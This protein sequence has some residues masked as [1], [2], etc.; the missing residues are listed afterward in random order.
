VLSFTGKDFGPDEQVTV[1]LNT[2]DGQPLEIIQ[3]SPEGSFE[4]AGGFLVPFGLH[5]KQTLIFIGQQSKA[6]TTASFDTLQ[7]TP[8]AQPSTY[9]GRP[10]TTLTFYAVGF[11]R[12]EIV[13]AVIDRT[14][15]SAGRE[16]SCFR[17]DPQGNAASA[18]SYV[19]PGDALPG[20]LIF[21]LLG[22]KS[23]AAATAALEVIASEVPVQVP[24]AADFQCELDDVPLGAPMVGATPVPV[25]ALPAAPEPVLGPAP[26][27]PLPA[28]AEAS[29]AQP[30]VLPQPQPTEAPKPTVQAAPSPST[31]AAAT[32]KPS[33]TTRPGAGATPKTGATA[34]PPKATPA[35]TPAAPAAAP[36]AAPPAATSYTIAAGDT[37]PSIAQ[38]VYGDANL[39]RR[40]Y[41]A[42]KES[43]GNNPNLIKPG[44]QLSIPPKES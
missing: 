23:E 41:D 6:P 5:G 26:A 42:N 27:S 37:L 35:A 32:A 39:W 4:N 12:S 29:A 34:Q 3:A 33:A 15:D 30:T 9:G 7:Y 17:T 16:V 14:K 28:P 8:S 22:S 25:P 2:P 19:V 31:K 20:Q 36:P 13:H 38:T 11:A 44:T 24:P 43:I 40:I 10:G 18:G 1:Y 21:T